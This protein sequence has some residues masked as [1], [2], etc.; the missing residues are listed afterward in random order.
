[1]LAFAKFRSPRLLGSC[2]LMPARKR[3]VAIKSSAY[4]VHRSEIDFSNKI[5][6]DPV[7]IQHILSKYWTTYVTDSFISHSKQNNE[8]T[9]WS[10]L[11]IDKPWYCNDTGHMNAPELNIA[12]NQMMY[13]TIYY[14]ISYSL[15]GQLSNNNFAVSLENYMDEVWP[16]FVITKIESQFVKPIQVNDFS[17]ALRIKNIT[18][19]P[20]DRHL[21]FDIDL[22][23]VAGSKQFPELVIKNYKQL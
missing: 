13:V 23:A 4:D 20:S 15:I 5:A 3:G 1:M 19:S 17:G 9:M 22:T 6:L 18:A 21:F 10:K 16:D 11:G 12:F 7:E 8:I 2:T 14:G